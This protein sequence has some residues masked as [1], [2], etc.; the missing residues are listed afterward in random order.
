MAQAKVFLT[1]ATGYS[2]Q[3]VLAELNRRGV[4]VTALVSREIGLSGCE[5]VVGDLAAV[6]AFAQD[7]RFVRRDSSGQSPG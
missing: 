1:G 6:G 4:P 7:S 3:P 2:G 5:T